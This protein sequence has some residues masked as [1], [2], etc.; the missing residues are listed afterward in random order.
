MLSR[1][2]RLLNFD[3]S[4]TRQPDFPDLGA[5]TTVDLTGLGPAARLWADRG[6]ADA[7]R[8]ALD[9]ALRDTIT[10]LG[11]GDYHYVSALL[12]EQFREP[13]SLVVFDHH[14]D[15]DRLPPR[16]GCGAWVSRALE[17]QNV[18]QILLVGN[19]SAD[20]AFP[21]IVTGSAGAMRSGR[22]LQLPFEAPARG[23][24]PWRNL[25]WRELKV[26][27]ERVF[28]AALEQLPRRQV[29][30]SIDKDCLTASSAL[31]NW[32]EGRLPLELL[33]SFLRRLRERC[34]IVGL[35][36]TG[37]YSTGPIPDRWKAWCSDF[38]HPADYSARGHLPEEIARRNGQTNQRILE[39]LTA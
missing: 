37:E 8:R 18:E 39:L 2:V 25:P 38:D 24:W 27:P 28:A 13:L 17:Q 32:E 15:W 14:P 22:V 29:Y 9:P 34:E 35:D 16:H 23:I 10:F 33:L 3:D 1:R 7:I 21:S 6:Q 31:T 19:A 26:D 30:V 4:V 20:L 36:V 12:L 11:S 5:A